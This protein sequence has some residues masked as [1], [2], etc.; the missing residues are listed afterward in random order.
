MLFYEIALTAIHRGVYSCLNF[1]TTYCLTDVELQQLKHAEIYKQRKMLLPLDLLCIQITNVS[2]S[3]ADVN[4]K[5]DRCHRKQRPE[6][7][8]PS[9]VSQRSPYRQL[10]C[11]EVQFEWYSLSISTH[12][13]QRRFIA[14][15]C[16][17]GCV[18]DVFTTH[19][20]MFTIDEYSCQ[21]RIGIFFSNFVCE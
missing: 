10:N 19:T 2:D 21:S 5:E 8:S 1:C 11:F 3:S 13:R 15:N 14:L 6:Y 12:E 9:P 20:H 4:G 18:D 7:Y 16:L 17:V